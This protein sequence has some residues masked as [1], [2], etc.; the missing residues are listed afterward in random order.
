LGVKLFARAWRFQFGCFQADVAQFAA[1]VIRQ[2]D[3]RRFLHIRIDAAAFKQTAELFRDGFDHAFQLFLVN[4][5]VGGGQAEVAPSSVVAR[6]SAIIMQMSVYAGFLDAAL[7]GLF[8]A[9]ELFAER[10][11]AEPSH[12][13]RL[14]LRSLAQAIKLPGNK[15]HH[16]LHLGEVA[17]TFMAHQI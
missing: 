11:Q 13:S 15:I 12:G 7:N 6:S 8:A 2:Q 14:N 17:M 16:Q 9:K 3:H 1:A 4:I 5:V 10:E